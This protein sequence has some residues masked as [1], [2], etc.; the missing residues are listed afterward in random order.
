MMDIIA[1]KIDFLDQQVRRQDEEIQ[2]Y[3]VGIENLEQ[4]N[5][6]LQ[7]EVEDISKKYEDLRSD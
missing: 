4:A 1:Q 5:V 7:T 6:T 2:G 3:K